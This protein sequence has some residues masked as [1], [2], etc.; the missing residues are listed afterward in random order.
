ML[1]VSSTFILAD[2]LWR[3]TV[4]ELLLIKLLVEFALSVPVDKDFDLLQAFLKYRLT[5]CWEVANDVL[6]IDGFRVRF[7]DEAD[8]VGLAA[9]LDEV[10]KVPRLRVVHF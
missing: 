10:L 3:H 1:A 9:L 2:H 8:N 5:D 6:E 4:L 7:L